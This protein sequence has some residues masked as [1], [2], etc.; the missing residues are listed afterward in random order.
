MLYKDSKIDVIYNLKHH[1][2][3]DR[4]FVDYEKNILISKVSPNLIGNNKMYSFILYLQKIVY[5]FYDNV[6]LIK[7][8]KN[9]TVDKYYYK[10]KN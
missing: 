10:H 2:D 1:H 6:N 7:N 9:Y 5:L 4:D 3:D 8:W